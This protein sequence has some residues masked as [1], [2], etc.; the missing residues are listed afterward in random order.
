MEHRYKRGTVAARGNV[1][2]AEIEGDGNTEP[3]RELVTVADL[4]RETRLRPMQNGLP[5]KAYDIDARA[6]DFVGAEE[7]LDRFDMPLGDQALGLGQ[8]ARALAAI[9]DLPRNL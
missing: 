3:A 5:V 2:G 9:R 6:I 1:R 8:H 7:S 4:H